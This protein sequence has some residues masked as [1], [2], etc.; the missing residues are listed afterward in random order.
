M[1]DGFKWLFLDLNSYFASVEQAENPELRNKPVAV[2]PMVSD[3]TCCIAASYEAKA[4]G[5]KTGTNVGEARRMCPGLILIQAKHKIYVEYHERILSV[6]DQ[7]LPIAKV[8]SIDELAC[9]LIGE[10]MRE[11]NAVR[12]ARNIKQAIKDQISPA[13]GCSVGLAPNRYLAKVAGDMQK[14]DGLTL[15]PQS[16]LPEILYKL[17]IRDFPGIG[18]RMEERFIKHGC[19]TVPKLYALSQ[20]GMKKIWGGVVGNYFWDLI[21]GRE[22]QEK[23][24]K[25]RT[26][27]HSNV[28]SPKRRNAEDAWAVCFK[29]LTKAC[30]RLREE[31]FFTTHLHLSVK[32]LGKK[33]DK[34][35]NWKAHVR[36]VETQDTLLLMREL[37]TLWEQMP[38]KKLLRVGIALSDLSLAS[39]HQ[40]SLFEEED[41][42]MALMSTI[43]KLNQRAGKNLVYF[44][45][46]HGTKHA[47]PARIAFNR[48]PTKTDFLPDET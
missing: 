29:L 22:I 35:N 37:R 28:L 12:I 10:E 2:V 11:E 43:D 18:P 45:G 44:A 26:I 48:I 36:T 40:K 24:T 1:A 20:E 46:T 39:K 27:S 4:F 13:L 19:D 8:M 34:K 25:H 7:F 21:R 30:M 6:V 41:K 23:I 14:P 38:R 31:E 9:E 15:I 32:F 3:T 47:A 5:V 33:G 42:N 16:A 17:K